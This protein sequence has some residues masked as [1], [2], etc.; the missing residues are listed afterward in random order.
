M[1][2]R[3]KP[4]GKFILIFGS[5]VVL[6][7]VFKTTGLWNKIFPEKVAKESTVPQVEGVTTSGVPGTTTIRLAH[8]TWNTHQGFALANKGKKTAPDSIFAE[9]GISMELKRMEEIPDQI[10]ALKLFASKLKGGD[11]NPSEGVHFI[12][13]MGDAGGWVL[14]S[15]M[16]ALDDL[17]S[18]YEP[19]VIGFGGFSA[20]EDKFMGLPEWKKNP[21]SSKG[22]LVAGVPADGDWNIMIFWCAQNGIPFN[23][24]KGTYD[25]NAL[26][27]LETDSF[28]QAGEVYISGKPVDLE[29]KADGKD[30]QGQK[31]KKGNKGKVAINGVVTWTP[32]DK[33]IA[34]KRGG[35]VSIAST[36]EYSNQMPMFIIGIKKWDRDNKAVVVKMLASLFKAADL[37]NRSDRDLRNRAIAP[38]SGQDYRWLGAK[39]VQELFESESPDYWYNFFEVTVVRDRK[40][41]DVEIGGSAVSNLP[42]NWKFFGLDGTTDIG[43][44][45]YNR[46]AK[47]AMHYY[48]EKMKNYPKWKDVFNSE[49]LK[50]V[51]NEFPEL[52]KSDPYL[53]V[54]TGETK[55][56]QI[57]EMTY[58]IP[59]E[60]GKAS[61]TGDSNKTLQEALEQLIIAA[62]SKVEVHGHTDSEGAEEDNM[63][64]SRRRGEAVYEWLKKQAGPSFPVNRVRVIPHGEKDLLAKDQA[65]G[66]LLPDKMAMNRR[67]VIKI[68]KN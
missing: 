26:N 37:I 43:E 16:N 11:A 61:F 36:K 35:L 24:Q 42:R 64:L 28:V 18:D 17:G 68:Y 60:S 62:N 30:Y 4:T 67:V 14:R 45:I 6:F 9:N 52:A 21:R 13:I 19:E 49:Y 15:A 66:K 20:G 57:G 55:G 38:R 27:F 12:T 1:A 53:P 39:Y 3:L 25:P 31:V 41:L 63:A 5:F 34:D 44:V 8:W 22:G 29:F 59:F 48:P 51:A 46:F 47:L 56:A 50:S 7:V 58:R 2:R 65:D 40:G 10:A 33:S 23:P 32:V 54:F